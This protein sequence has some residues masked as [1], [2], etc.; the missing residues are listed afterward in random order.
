MFHIVEQLCILF[1]FV[2][3]S[4]VLVIEWVKA[5]RNTTFISPCYKSDLFMIFIYIAILRIKEYSSLISLPQGGYVTPSVCLAFSR[6]T[7]EL[8]N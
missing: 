1:L 6:T 8:R 4:P 3:F 5:T 7:Q 2:C